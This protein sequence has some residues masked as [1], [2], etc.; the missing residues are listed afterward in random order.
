MMLESKRFF[1]KFVFATAASF[2]T[3]VLKAQSWPDKAIKMVLGYTTGGA[4]DATARII[5][6]P[7][8]QIIKQPVIMEYKPGAGASIGAEFVAKSIP[9]GY[10][11]GLTDTGPLCIMPNLRKVAYD[12]LTSFTPLSYVCTTGL[13]LIVNPELQVKNIQELIALTKSKPGK[14]SYASSGVGSVHHLAGE[15]FKVRAGVA[16]VHIP[17]RGAGPALV[18]L[19]GGQIPIM[20]ATIGPALPMIAAGKARAL[21]VTSLTR[22]TSL[23]NIPTIAEQ[24]LKGYEAVLRFMVMGPAK[25][26]Q[27][28]ASKLQNDFKT[29]ITDSTV[30]SELRKQGN[31]DISYKS[32]TEIETLI[33]DDYRKWGNL[34][35]DLK[36]TLDS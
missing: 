31:D 30:I 25:L 3:L 35:R 23:P 14:F 18:D 26:P 22:S 1:L 34:I 13:V 16:I 9:D 33:Q 8:E 2:K 15:L 20:F 32:P 4:T 6:R 12:P 21:G 7:L 28:V 17:Y 29:V 36:I 24:G 11:V 19:V 27:Q 5:S 10:T